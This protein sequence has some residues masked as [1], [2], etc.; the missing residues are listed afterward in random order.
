MKSFNDFIRSLLRLAFDAEL[1]Q[2]CPH[3]AAV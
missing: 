3:R 2:Q 1:P